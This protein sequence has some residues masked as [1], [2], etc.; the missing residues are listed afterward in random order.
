MSKDAN[1]CL[2]RFLGLQISISNLN[3]IKYLDVSENFSKHIFITINVLFMHQN[4]F[5]NIIN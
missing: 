2:L 1:M 4:N 3:K 5:K